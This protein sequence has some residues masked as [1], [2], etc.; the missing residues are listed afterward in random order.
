M[1]S[2]TGRRT[3][4]RPGCE[5]RYEEVHSEIPLGLWRAFVDAGV[6]EWHIWRDGTTLFHS[7]TTRASFSETMAAFERSGW[8]D[9]EWQETIDQL[10]DDD[11][12]THVTLS[13]VWAM[14]SRTQ[15][16]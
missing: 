9:P 14:D 16:T 13:H 2:T 6:L 10:V 3:K 1:T 8:S 5:A 11:D 15:W 12:A 4:L 7:I